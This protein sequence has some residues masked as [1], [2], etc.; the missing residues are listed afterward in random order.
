MYPPEDDEWYQAMVDVG[1]AWC[2][3]C[4]EYHRPPECCID[5]DGN[6]LDWESNPW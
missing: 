1:Y 4:R 6:A 2:R 5:Q 3:P